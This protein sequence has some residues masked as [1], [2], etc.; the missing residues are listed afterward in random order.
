MGITD[1]MDMNLSKLLEIVKDRGARHTAVHGV[2]QSQTGLSDWTIVALQCCV[3]F[4]RTMKQIS[5]MHAYIPSLM[6]LP[7]T[8][9]SHPSGS[10]QG[11]ELSSLGY[12][13]TPTNDL[14]YTWQ[15]KTIILILK[16]WCPESSVFRGAETAGPSAMVLL[17]SYSRVAGRGSTCLVA[18]ASKWDHVI[19][20]TE[21]VGKL[22]VSLPGFSAPKPSQVKKQLCF[23][24]PPFPHFLTR[25]RGCWGLWGW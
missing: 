4:C 21:W 7:P 10:P 9:W 18:S 25:P 6:G 12:I 14:L 22:E 19:T 3:N 17:P 5:Y 15:C 11:T 20:S 16:N 13:A 23:F 1:S 24:L 2:T 8:P